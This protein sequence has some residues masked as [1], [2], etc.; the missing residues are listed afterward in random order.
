MMHLGLKKQIAM[1]AL[2][3]VFNM[4]ARAEDGHWVTTWGTAV[5]DIRSGFW[6]ANGYFPPLPLENNTMRMFVRTS[7]GGELFR[8]RFSNAYGT[9]PVTINSAHFALAAQSDS[10]AGI[11]DIQ[12]ETDTVLKFSG[13]PAVVIPPGG[14][15]YSDPVKYS[16]P[17]LSVIAVSLQYGEISDDPIT[18]HRG[19]RTT[20]FFAT[21][22]AVSAADMSA[23]TRKDVWYTLAGIETMA[24]ASG[25]TLIALGDSITDGN[26]TTYNYNTRWTD[27]LAA[28]LGDN[29]PTAQVGVAN[30]GIGGSGSAMAQERFQR[31]VLDQSAAR[32]VVV[33]IGVND[34]IYGN[35]SSSYLISAY[36]DMAAKA[37]ARGLKIYGATITPMCDAATAA[38][39]SV[40]QEVNSWI[41]TT[42]MSNGIYDG[43]IDFDAAMRDPAATTYTLTAYRNNG[44]DDLHMNA[45]GY[46]AM[47]DSIDL[48]LFVDP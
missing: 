27:Y 36:T 8:F 11:G 14:V 41:R 9:S 23:A 10:S 46:E 21:G 4:G 16:L 34:I 12:T 20:S 39:E 44:T 38:Q 17:A 31:D 29:A 22:N 18:G 6:M 28:R 7:I 43:Y 5:E 37:H 45:A 35:A 47:A 13:A 32:W 24:P 42:A 33:F 15:V 48:S 3:A 1:L 30:M 2:L 40:R 19:S 25:K 26:G